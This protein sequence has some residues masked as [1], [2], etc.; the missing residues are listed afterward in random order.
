MFYSRKAPG[1]GVGWFSNFMI[2]E[3]TSINDWLFIGDYNDLAANQTTLFAVW[4][5]RRHQTSI[6]AYEDNVFGSRIIA[7][8]GMGK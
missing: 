3:A 8:G 4:T 5:D 7:G 6:F 2:S 1:K